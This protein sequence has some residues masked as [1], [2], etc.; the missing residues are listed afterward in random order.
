MLPTMD[1]ALIVIVVAII[2]LVCWVRVWGWT[3]SPYQSGAEWADRFEERHGHGARL[4][5][6]TMAGGICLLVAMTLD[7][8]YRSGSEPYLGVL[9]AGILAY[10]VYRYVRY[11]VSGR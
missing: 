10:F 2:G 3:G 5:L 7:S 1:G 6:G 9:G 11:R 4:L 8:P